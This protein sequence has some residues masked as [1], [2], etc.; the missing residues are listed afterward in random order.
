M[1]PISETNKETWTAQTWPG[2]PEL[3]LLASCKY[4]SHYN[5][6][7]PVWVFGGTADYPTFSFCVSAGANSSFS[8]S[9]TT[10]KTDIKEAEIFVDELNKAH[11]L[12]K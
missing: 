4:F 12:I 6:K 1:K 3:N 9:G 11:K 7:I 2:N 8:Y 10:G 5:S